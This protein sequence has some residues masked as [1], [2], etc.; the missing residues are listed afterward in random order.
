MSNIYKCIGVKIEW[1][2][3]HTLLVLLR[4]KNPSK[5]L[6]MIL[7]ATIRNIVQNKKNLADTKQAV[8]YVNMQ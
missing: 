2:K 8:D 1:V 4:A 5:N 7:S 6:T 3:K